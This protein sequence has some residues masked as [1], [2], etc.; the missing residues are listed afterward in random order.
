MTKPIEAWPPQA[1]APAKPSVYTPNDLELVELVKTWL[2]EHNK[3]RAWL[4]GITRIPNGTI[5]QILSGKYASSPSRQLGTMLSCLNVEE[6]RLKDGTSGYIKGS[7]HQLL[8]VVYERTRKHQSFGVVTGYVG[9]GKTRTATEYANTTPLTVLVEASPHMTAGVLLDVLLDQLNAP[10]PAGLDRK[11][12]EVLKALR[13]TNFLIIVDEAEKVSAPALEYLR[14]IRDMAKVGIVLQ[15]TEKLSALIKPQ[16]GTFDQIRSRV[17]MWPKTIE[18]ISRNDADDM[19]RA[20]L[21]D[22]GELA[23]EVLD[24]LWAYGEGSARMLNENLVPAIKDY[25]RGALTAALVHK[26]FKTVLRMDAP[27]VQ[28]GKA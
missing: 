20:A 17:Q 13:G 27:K 12:R 26:I 16:H 19:A 14:R 5:S 3:P 11:F 9:V 15:G 1:D 6:E 2:T 22:A 4:S 21:A 7:V 25:G 24:A 23:D 28:G 10:A 18:C 8:E